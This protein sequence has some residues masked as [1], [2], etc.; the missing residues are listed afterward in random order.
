MAFT[1]S[2]TLGTKRN[3][4]SGCRQSAFAI[5]N[6]SES[7]LGGT[8]FRTSQALRC[9][10]VGRAEARHSETLLVTQRVERIEP[11]GFARRIKAKENAD[12]RADEK[13]AD[14]GPRRDQGGPV[15]QRGYYFRGRD[16]GDDADDAADGAERDRLNQELSEDIAAVRANRHACADL[17]RTA[18]ISSLS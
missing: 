7:L 9:K 11:G 4:T 1:S 8:C 14:D 10:K 3:G 5:L 16:A 17:A 13:R 18:A 6:R 15:L 2:I 12:R